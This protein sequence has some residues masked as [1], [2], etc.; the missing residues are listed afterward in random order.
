VKA[1]KA[2]VAVLAAGALLVGCGGSEWSGQVRFKVTDIKPDET[3]VSGAKWP[4]RVSL[5]LDQEQPDG[6]APITTAW[7]KLTDVPAGTA[8]GDVLVCTVRERDD[9]KFDDAEPVQEFGPCEK[10]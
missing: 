5:D 9:S 8:V 6:L 7:A 10:P 3:L 4:G 2:C 1:L